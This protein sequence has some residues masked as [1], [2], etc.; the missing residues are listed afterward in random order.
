MW[1]QEGKSR[2]EEPGRRGQEGGARN[3]KVNIKTW[4]EETKRRYQK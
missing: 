1:S 3:K 2:S 4:N